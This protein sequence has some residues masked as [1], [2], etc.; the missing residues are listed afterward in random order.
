MVRWLSIGVISY[1]ILGIIWWGMLLLRKN[2]D[3]FQLQSTDKTEVLSSEEIQKERTRQTTMIMGEGFVLVL[4][5]LCG[6]YLINRSA[7]REIQ[8]ARQQNDFL[9]SVSH[10][11]KSPIAAIKL[12]L[13]TLN[14]TNIP[15]EKET[16]FLNSALGDSDRLEKMVQNILLTTNIDSQPLELYKAEIDF[17]VLLKSIVSHYNSITSQTNIQLLTT[18][19]EAIINVDEYN[20]KQAIGNI[21]DN[22]IKYSNIDQPI[23]VELTKDQ[24]YIHCA[25]ENYGDEISD[26][27]KK[28]IFDKF[29]RI[30]NSSVRKKEGTGIG[31]Y[32]SNEIIKAHGGQISV[33]SAQGINRFN[34]SLPLN[35]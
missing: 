35:V 4:L 27:Q 19:K 1:M 11:L 22:A 17:N 6:I 20:I 14:R 30:D 25:I 2:E 12:A 31:L 28:K 34:I 24:N 15:K 10:E 21:I 26:S 7:Q 13:Q 18:V 33:Q 16:K 32:I 8:A 9:L 23:Q 3:I 5:L 29:Y